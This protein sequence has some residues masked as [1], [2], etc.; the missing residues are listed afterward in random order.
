MKYIL[1][2]QIESN[3]GYHE[4]IPALEG[5]IDDIKSGFEAKQTEKVEWKI[6]IERV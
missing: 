2:I 5:V 1:N 4:F 6:D 3:E